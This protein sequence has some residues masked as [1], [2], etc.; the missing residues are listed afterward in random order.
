MKKLLYA[1]H[2]HPNFSG[3]Y[4][5]VLKHGYGPGALP[6][7]VVVIQGWDLPNG[8]T[9]VVTDKFM[10]NEE[11]SEYDIPDET[12]IDS[13]LNRN[14]IKAERRSDGFYDLIDTDTN[15]V[16]EPW[17]D[18]TRY[19]DDIIKTSVK[20]ASTVLRDQDITSTDDVDELVLY[21]TNDGDLY[22]SRALHIISNLARKLKR[23]SYD[24]DLAIKAW[25]Y[26]ADDGVRKY[27]KEFVSGQGKLFLD[28]ATRTAIA[29]ELR[30]YYEEQVEDEANVKACSDVTASDDVATVSVGDTIW[31][32]F[33]DGQVE[34][35]TII[36]ATVKEVYDDHAIVDEGDGSATWMS[37]DETFN[38]MDFEEYVGTDL[39]TFS[40]E[41]DAKAYFE[42]LE[43]HQKKPVWL[44]K[45]V[46]AS[47]SKAS[48]NS[49]V[50]QNDFE[51]CVDNV[52]KYFEDADLNNISIGVV[53]KYQ[54]GIYMPNVPID[55][56]NAVYYINSV[57]SMWAAVNHQLQ[58]NKT[59]HDTI[60][61]AVMNISDEV[62]YYVGILDEGMSNYD[63]NEA[64][65]LRE[66]SDIDLV[67]N[68]AFTLVTAVCNYL[69]QYFNVVVAAMQAD[70][71]SSDYRRGYSPDII[72]RDWFIPYK[73]GIVYSSTSVNQNHQIKCANSDQ[74]IA[75]QHQKK[76]VWLSKDVTASSS[77]D[78]IVIFV[79]G[80]EI[81]NGPTYYMADD[82]KQLFTTNPDICDK[83]AQEV[84]SYGVSDMDDS[85]PSDVADHVIWLIENELTDGYDPY[86][87]VGNVEI[88]PASDIAVNAATSVE[89]N[90][91]D[92]VLYERTFSVKH[93]GSSEDYTLSVVVEDLPNGEVGYSVYCPKIQDK[94]LETFETSYD[95]K[96]YID[97]NEWDIQLPVGAEVEANDRDLNS[98][99][100]DIKAN[101]SK[102]N[103][104][105]DE[106]M[107]NSL[108]EDAANSIS[109]EGDIIDIYE[110][111]G[112]KVV[113][114]FNHH[115]VDLDERI[116]KCVTALNDVFANTGWHFKFD[117]CNGD[118]VLIFN[119][120]QAE[121]DNDPKYYVA[122]YF[123]SDLRG[124]DDNLATDDFTTAL[125]FAHELASNGD[126]IE[127]INEVTGKA[128]S[129]TPD[130]W[131]EAI[132][133][134]DVPSDVYEVE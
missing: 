130:R 92:N 123:S 61:Q 131:M 73:G 22:R 57:T 35:P 100:T 91:S 5:Y 55:E 19:A 90:D 64:E 71:S 59:F 119:E 16:V 125:D 47:S 118:N 66:S 40:N 43:Q 54:N 75:E 25:Q 113:I 60:E 28:K 129:Y 128:K 98:S 33:G 44:S 81:Y 83:F 88:F 85:D 69:D 105:L 45:D 67:I 104:A 46:T 63:S 76:P 10:D 133:F 20:S 29:K 107:M 51:E 114:T 7:D 117:N 96:D 8:Y 116:A 124:L 50:L 84:R 86:W 115:A 106:E 34:P 77:N 14:H 109:G 126:Y 110:T 12:K 36:P 102:E 4:M 3:G 94:Y 103:Y 89:A 72:Y 30:D 68:A 132:E 11:L 6:K 38:N 80:T 95:A 26:L 70:D 74:D 79:D 121:D 65:T 112:M 41:A 99:H 1:S 56:Y 62:N 78:D 15:E 82:L 13:M 52:N 31:T 37:L 120:L 93:N 134:G 17:R 87:T 48:T 111:D 39:R 122:G 27:D 58:N 97:S 9:V 23:G 42:Y 108:L 53:D 49:E 127:I 2:R 24:K 101:L 32:V 21:I 18:D